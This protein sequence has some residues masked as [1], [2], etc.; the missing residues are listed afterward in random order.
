MLTVVLRGEWAEQQWGDAA[1]R[2][3]PSGTRGLRQS[4]VGGRGQV[5]C[6]WWRWLSH[7]Q[8]H[9]VQWE[10]VSMCKGDDLQQGVV[11]CLS[12]VV[13]AGKSV[14]D[15]L[16]VGLFKW[17]F[18]HPY[19]LSKVTVTCQHSWYWKLVCG[20]LHDSKEHTVKVTVSMVILSHPAFI[21]N[22]PLA[23]DKCKFLH[24]LQDLGSLTWVRQ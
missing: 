8:C 17:M 15:S 3:L 11:F 6:H 24:C 20:F 5:W 10:G 7:P 21:G 19:A 1:A 18:L 22:R 16:G 4:S 12:V 9:E 13:T 23:V 2:G 14:Q